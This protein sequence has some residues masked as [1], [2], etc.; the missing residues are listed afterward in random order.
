M[1]RTY[2]CQSCGA[3]WVT[4]SEDEARERA[5]RCLRCD[6]ALIL[7]EPPA[8]GPGAETDAPPPV[9]NALEDDAET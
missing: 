5:G 2:R 3:A 8:A 6:G 7:D 9:P 4:A 1:R